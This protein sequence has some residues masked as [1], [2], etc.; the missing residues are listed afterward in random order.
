[1]LTVFSTYTYKH[2][3]IETIKQLIY[4]LGYRPISEQTHVECPK[5]EL[6][7]YYKI[8]KLLNPNSK[9]HKAPVAI[10]TRC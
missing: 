8:D 9:P 2:L 1:M 6:L 4:E 5:A 7:V 3:K 10:K